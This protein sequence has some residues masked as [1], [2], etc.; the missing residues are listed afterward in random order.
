MKVKLKKQAE[1]E[2]LTK[3]A[4][5]I[6]NKL[7]E[8]NIQKQKGLLTHLEINA[9]KEAEEWERQNPKESKALD[10]KIRNIIE[11]GNQF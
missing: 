1:I 11:K 9:F 4:I 7:Q 5:Q 2:E 8:L 10:E 6:S 3:I